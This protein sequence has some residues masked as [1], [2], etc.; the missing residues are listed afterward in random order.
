MY[1][2]A[3]VEGERTTSEVAIRWIQHAHAEKL[4]C[5][6]RKISMR[7]KINFRARENIFLCAQKFICFRKKIYLT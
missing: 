4:L 5:A 7:S 1:A 6:R 3:S 2:K